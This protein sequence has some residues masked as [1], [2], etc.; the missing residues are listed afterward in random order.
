MNRKRAVLTICG[1]VAA[2]AG[3][4]SADQVM[5]HV[6]GTDGNLGRGVAVSLSGGLNFW[7]GST[8]KTLWAGQLSLDVDGQQVKSYSAELTKVAGDGWHEKTAATDSLD[9]LR[10]HAINSLFNANNGGEFQSA[11]E[12]V[13]FQALLWEVMYDYTGSPDSIDLNSGHVAFGEVNA[14]IF[15]VMKSSGFRGG[16]DPRVE[17]IASEVFGDHFSYG[18]DP[19]IVPLPTSA[20]F[21]GAGLLGLAAR[22]RRA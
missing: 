7:D 1:A 19:R 12:A 11:D 9:E 10:A 2:A 6:Q 8:S 14:D 17:V 3:V 21:A 20:A 15:E 5:V 13:A 22:R 16:D 18:Q 4:A